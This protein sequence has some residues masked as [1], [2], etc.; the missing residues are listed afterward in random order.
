MKDFWKYL[1]NPGRHGLPCWT[2]FNPY[3]KFWFAYLLSVV[4]VLGLTGLLNIFGGSVAD[5]VV[6]QLS[7]WVHTLFALI[8]DLLVLTHIYFK[9]IRT[10]FRDICDMAKCLK[11]KGDINYPFLYDHNSEGGRR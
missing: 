11:N 10:I 6:F 9:I 5:P 7:L 2:E 4:P 1:K 3:H 8:T